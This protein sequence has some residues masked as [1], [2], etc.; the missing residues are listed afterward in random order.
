MNHSSI[1]IWQRTRSK[2][3]NL[4][5]T[6]VVSQQNCLI[7]K[8]IMEEAYPPMPPEIIEEAMVREESAEQLLR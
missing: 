5:K 6:V 7:L 3:V 4:S 8:N 2:H 1:A